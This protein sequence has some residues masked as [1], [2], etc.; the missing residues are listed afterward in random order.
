ML[1]LA[2]IMHHYYLG[3]RDGHLGVEGAIADLGG[4]VNCIDNLREQSRGGGGVS[5]ANLKKLRRGQGGALL[6]GQRKSSGKASRTT[7]AYS[8]ETIHKNKGSDA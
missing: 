8:E 6:G 2:R 7:F 4:G 3:G 5:C 1:W